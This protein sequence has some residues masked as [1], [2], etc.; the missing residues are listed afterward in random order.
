MKTILLPYHDEEAGR[1]A[2][3]AAIRLATRFGSYLEGLLVLGPPPLTL[4]PGMSL[5][6]DFVTTIA[7]EGRKF[8]TTAREH[9]LVVAEENGLPF[10]ELRTAGEGAAAGWREMD[11]KESEIVG[12]YARLFDLTVMGRSASSPSAR[13]RDTCEAALFESGRPVLL[14][15]FAPPA[16][17]GH[18]IL[19]AWNGST[20]TARTIAYATPLLTNAAKV[21]VLSVAGN[22]MPGPTGAQVAEHLARHGVRVESRTITPDGRTAG[23]VILDE[24]S[25]IGADLLIKGAYTRHRLRQI[26]FGGT[27]QHVLEFARIPVFLA[28]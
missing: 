10:R 14:A 20:E 23:E 28:H 19:I 2:L 24:A 3:N 7:N 25:D 26:I 18:V 27:T 6:P 8:A 17:I 11:G 13:W 21:E 12:W 5:S 1:T 4:G 9:F 16:R 22:V 15:P